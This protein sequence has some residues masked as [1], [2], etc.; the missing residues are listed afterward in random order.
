M[1]RSPP[2]CSSPGNGPPG[3]LAATHRRPAAWRSAR[4]PA[5]G[6][7]AQPPA[8][9]QHLLDRHDLDQP[10]ARRWRRR[11]LRRAGEAALLI[12]YASGGKRGGVERRGRPR[13]PQP[14]GRGGPAGPVE[15]STTAPDG[16]TWPRRG[17]SAPAR[18]SRRTSRSTQPSARWFITDQATS[19]LRSLPV[20]GRVLTARLYGRYSDWHI[21]EKEPDP[22][23]PFDTRIK[24]PYLGVQLIHYDTREDPVPHA[25]PASTQPPAAVRS[26]APT[27]ST[28]AGTG[29]S[30]PSCRLGAWRGSG[31]P[32]RSRCGSG[33][34][35]AFAG[36]TYRRALQEL[37][38]STRCAATRLRASARGK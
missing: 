15:S 12:A 21:Y 34:P 14:A 28:C 32:G 17:C 18:R 36:Q 24:H 30:T 27:T 25:W 6:G 1:A 31:S 33:W 19:A 3:E 26:W 7:G 10:P 38:A 5:P 2:P 4:P 22:F 37:A 11:H 23:F 13:R 20:L 29:R 16:C 9:H 35:G 8:G